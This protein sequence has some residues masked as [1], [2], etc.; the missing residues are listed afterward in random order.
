MAEPIYPP[1]YPGPS[2]R[3]LCDGG[4]VIPR[5][6]TQPGWPHDEPATVVPVDDSPSA[7][8]A[9]LTSGDTGGE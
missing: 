2:V 4:F 3:I 1:T 8:I 5:P 9:R 6:F 7:L